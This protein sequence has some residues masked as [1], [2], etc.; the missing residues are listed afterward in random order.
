MATWGQTTD[1]SGVEAL[2]GNLKGSIGQFTVAGQQLDSMVVRFASGTGSVRGAVYE[3]SDGDP[4]GASLV[5]DLGTET[6]SGASEVTFTSST[7]P[8]LTQN[9]YLFLIVKTDVSGIELDDNTSSDGDLAL[10]IHFCNS[11]DSDEG[12]AFPAT[13]SDPTFLRSADVGTLYIN[14]SAAPAGGSIAPK[15]HFYRQQQGVG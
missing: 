13:M 8:T 15:V 11:E 2:S 10:G 5:E 4:N 6:A 12:V 3:K 1:G 9:N 7:N 14:H